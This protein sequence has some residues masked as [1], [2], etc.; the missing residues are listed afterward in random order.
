MPNR[1]RLA[2]L[3]AAALAAGAVTLLTL[4]VASAG[5]AYS[6]YLPLVRKSQPSATPTLEPSATPTNTPAPTVA[7][8]T[9]TPTQTQ[10]PAN[11][12]HSYPTVC[13]PPPPPDLDCP[14]IPYT[15]FLVVPPDDHH[16][17]QDHDGIG[18]ESP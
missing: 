12:D 8:P 1:T 11:C 18:C 6:N 16:F 9:S 14:D 13:I 5:P 15:N 2:I 4:G 3:L 17:D 7:L 10:Q